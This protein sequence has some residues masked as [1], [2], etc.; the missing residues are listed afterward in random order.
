M[1]MQCN[2]CLTPAAGRATMPSGGSF[3]PIMEIGDGT[4]TSPCSRARF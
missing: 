1:A 4:E 3:T 2:S